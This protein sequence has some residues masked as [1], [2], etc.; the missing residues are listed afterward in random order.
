MVRADSVAAAAP[1]H[2]STRM[3]G[4]ATSCGGELPPGEMRVTLPSLSWSLP[5]D[6]RDRLLL[7]VPPL[8]QVRAGEALWA[9]GGGMGARRDAH[10]KMSMAWRHSGSNS[11]Y[12][13]CSCML[14]H[15]GRNCSATWLS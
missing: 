14:R 13:C 1:V 11:G 3:P 6:T 12:R 7:L 9:P 10:A 8:L 2:Q 15:N 5:V 4:V